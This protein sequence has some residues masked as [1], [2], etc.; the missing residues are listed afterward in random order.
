V[1]IMS[2]C[3]S[4]TDVSVV[5][6]AQ[7][8]VQDPSFDYPHGVV[9]FTVPCNSATLRLFFRGS[10]TPAPPYRKYGP[11]TPG[12]P[13]SAQWYSFPGAVFGVQIVGGTP[14]R[15]VTLSL[16]DDALGD[17]TGFDGVIVDPGGP[18]V[19]LIPV[20][21]PGGVAALGV[22]LAASAAGVLRARRSATKRQGRDGRVR[23]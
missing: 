13:A 5:S 6:E 2:G 12:V 4:L 1:E 10:P 18:G 8:S 15:T 7:I 3:A 11:T 16:T 14:V 21:P 22:L 23:T 9:G 17:A 19:S 20:F